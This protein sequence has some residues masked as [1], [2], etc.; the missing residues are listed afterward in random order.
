MQGNLYILTGASTSGK[1]TLLN[2]I[3]ENGY[4]MKAPKFAERISR[5]PD[6]D[7]IHFD[8]IE[9]SNC[10][11]LYVINGKRYGIDTKLIKDEIKKGMDL[12]VILSDLRVIRR[13]KSEF[14]DHAKAIYIS[15]AIDEENVVKEQA[16]RNT[17]IPTEKQKEELHTQFNRLKSASKLELWP[18]VVDC[19][20]ELL[21]SWKDAL[22]ESKSTEI[23]A[24]KIRAFHSRYIDNIALFDHVILNYHE[25]EEMT[26]QAVGIINYYKK[27][28]NTKKKETPVIFMVSA[29]SGAGKGTLM[30][31]LNI[32]GSYQISIVSKMGQREGKKNDKRDGMIAIGAANEFSPEFDWRWEFHKGN[33]FKGVRYAVSITEIEKNIQD[34]KPQIFISNLGQIEKAKKLFGNKMVFIYLHATRTEEEIGTF[35]YAN[36][37]TREEAEKRIGE[38]YD[39]HKSYIND[40]ANI[41]HVL[42]NTTYEE[43]LYDQMFRLIEHYKN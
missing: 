10:D 42:L 28:P 22:P 19:M 17:F 6:D 5:G 11:V 3:L 39:V 23:R 27:N 36:C 29:A 35:Q 25:P 33:N 41:D 8:N 9:K 12:F 43:D 7:I 26:K 24:R 2:N 34:G 4:A 18:K 37:K 38:I 20:G 32:M 16:K 21:D 13:L 15:S 30:E 14:E 31:C 40:I 1:T